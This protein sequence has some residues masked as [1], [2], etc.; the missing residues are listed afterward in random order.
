ML[1]KD[2][3]WLKWSHQ[4]LSVESCRCISILKYFLYT[5]SMYEDQF[6]GNKHVTFI[7]VGEPATQVHFS[8]FSSHLSLMCCIIICSMPKFCTVLS[9]LPFVIVPISDHAEQH[10]AVH[11]ALTHG[12]LC[13]SHILG[14]IL[15]RL[16][17]YPYILR[18]F[19]LNGVLCV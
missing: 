17:K 3:Q 18:Y 2:L 13:M 9:A 8:Q 10:Y 7:C 11:T 15:Q 6:G 5:L 14:L 16:S 12:S 1:R 19:I 4:N